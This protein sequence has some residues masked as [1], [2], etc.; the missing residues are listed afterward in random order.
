[1]TEEESLSEESEVICVDSSSKQ[2][3]NLL[4]HPRGKI[5]CWRFFGFRVDDDG[6][7]TDMKQILCRL[8][9]AGLSYSGN[10]TTMKY[11]IQKHNPEHL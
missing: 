11:H 5:K 7:I 6:N 10:T 8:C 1:M 9:S 2:Q 3:Q 4:S